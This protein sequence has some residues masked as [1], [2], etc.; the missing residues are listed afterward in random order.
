MFIKGLWNYDIG[1]LDFQGRSEQILKT[2]Q[3]LGISQFELIKLEN[4]SIFTILRKFQ[5]ILD[6]ILRITI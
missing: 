4:K 1:K 5:E 3:H 6:K 2:R